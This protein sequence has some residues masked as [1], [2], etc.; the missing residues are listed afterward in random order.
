MED[1]SHPLS[2]VDRFK[3]LADIAS[4]DSSED[5]K[6]HEHTIPFSTSKLMKILNTCPGFNELTEQL[7]TL[8]DFT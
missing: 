7:P 3:E 6:P 2:R 5:V 4:E 8:K 1:E